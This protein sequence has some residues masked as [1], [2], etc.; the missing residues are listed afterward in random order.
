MALISPSLASPEG[1]HTICVSDLYTFRVLST[2]NES[3]T[4][5]LVWRG[6][7]NS[8]GVTSAADE[9]LWV[10]RH[11]KMRFEYA[12]RLGIQEPLTDSE[13]ASKP[14]TILLLWLT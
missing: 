4:F 3:D 14:N 2:T 10:D 13:Q 6:S 7:G 5:F 8:A 12:T 11:Q 9:V 1:L